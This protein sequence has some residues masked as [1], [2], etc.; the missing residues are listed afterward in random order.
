MN[1]KLIIYLVLFI[2]NTLNVLGGFLLLPEMISNS[3][4]GG[5]AVLAGFIY[6]DLLLLKKVK[7]YKMNKED[8]QLKKQSK[9]DVVKKD[10]I[11]LIKAKSEVTYKHN[12]ENKNNK[13][14]TGVYNHISGLPLSQDIQC[15]LFLYDDKIVIE[16][17]GVNFNLY[18]DKILDVCIKTDV[19][20]QKQY[21]SSIGG[22]IAGEAIFGTLGAIIGGRAK[23]KESK[24]VTQYLIYTYEKNNNINYLVF[25]ILKNVK[26]GKFVDD[27]R[28]LKKINKEIEL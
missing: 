16:S 6:L 23:Q 8:I 11:N 2:F 15:K 21:V 3:N 25:D 17:S 14:L 4:L 10:D 28:R 20:I 7:L 5:L 27:F 22:A 1:K 13:I 19:E 18:K 26:A 9:E 12:T 24:T